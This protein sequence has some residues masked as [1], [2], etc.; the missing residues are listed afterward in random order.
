MIINGFNEK[1]LAEKTGIALSCISLYTRGLQ[2]P[3][4]QALVKLADCFNCPI[5][6]LLGRADSYSAKKFESCPPFAQRFNELL[7]SC[8]CATFASFK[9]TGIS[10]S[11]FYEW[12][13]GKSLPTLDNLI[14]LAE[15]FNCSVDYL[16][17]RES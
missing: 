16:L 7:K 4:L 14:I 12:K 15:Y 5:D 17:G 10:K 3:Y 1:T 2:A 13:R 11:S 6:Y 8:N 9:D